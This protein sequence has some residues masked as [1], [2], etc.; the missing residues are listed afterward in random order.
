MD[1]HRPHTLDAALR[2]LR[3]RRPRILAGGTDVFP[4]LQN[5]PLSGEV[6]DLGAVAELRGLSRSAAGWR[7]GAGTTWTEIIQ[8]Q[9]PPSFLAL[10][11]AASEVGSVQIQNR[12]TI[13]GN[14]CNASPAADGVP[15]LLVLDAEVELAGLDGVRR[16]PLE[17]FIL[18]N[19]KTGLTIGE[20]LTAVHIPALADSGRSHFLKLGTRASLVIS[21]AMVAA[22]ISLVNGRIAACAIAVGACSPVARRLRR[23]EQALIGQHLSDVSIGSEALDGLSPI[24]DVRATATYRTSAVAELVVRA[25]REAAQ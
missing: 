12:A 6:L 14:L 1:Y 20:L 9:L 13:G 15:P 10:Q 24:D 5:R 4:A 3:Q 17:H 25:L 8:A 23:L 16:L 19:R 11:Q 7:I 22:R 18:G 2:D 21:I